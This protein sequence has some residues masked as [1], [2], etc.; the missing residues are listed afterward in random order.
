MPKNKKSKP[1]TN[2]KNDL[3]KADIELAGENGLEQI[4]L[5]AQKKSK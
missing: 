2:N 4:A 1:F 3:P 5:R